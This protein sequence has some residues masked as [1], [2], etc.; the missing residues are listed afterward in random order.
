MCFVAFVI[1]HKKARQLFN[2]CV[3]FQDVSF[4]SRG[5]RNMDPVHQR[6]SREQ[7]FLKSDRRKKGCHASEKYPDAEI[8]REE[9]LQGPGLAQCYPVMAA[10][11]RSSQS[12]I[13]SLDQIPVLDNYYVL[14]SENYFLVF[15]YCDKFILSTFFFVSTIYAINKQYVTK[16][17]KNLSFP[18]KEERFREDPISK[19][20]RLVKVWNINQSINYLD[21]NNY[22]SRKQLSTFCSVSGIPACDEMMWGMMMA[23]TITLLRMELITSGPAVAGGRKLALDL[24]R[25]SVRPGQD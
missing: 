11:I 25:E 21:D 15:L 17:I 12:V 3:S 22:R 24:G 18:N 7:S 6:L 20:C 9:L 1:L 5:K 23:R 16:A 14:C 13:L 4:K 19:T 2:E 8:P 10:L